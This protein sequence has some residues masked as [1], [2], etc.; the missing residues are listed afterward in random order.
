MAITA[1]SGVRQSPRVAKKLF[2]DNTDIF[3]SNVFYIDLQKSNIRKRLQEKIQKRGGKVD[4]F[5]HKD[6]QYVI[7]DDFVPNNSKQPDNAPNRPGAASTP[8]ALS[9]GQAL[10]QK[11]I[12]NTSSTQTIPEKAKKMGIKVVNLDF[13]QRK[14]K[15]R[16][17]LATTLDY[18]NK[19]PDDTENVITHWNGDPYIKFED[20]QGQYRPFYSSFERFPYIQLESNV[21]YDRP[22]HDAGSHTIH[23]K[24]K[25]CCTPPQIHKLVTK[26]GQKS[27]GLTS[28][29]KSRLAKNGKNEQAGYCE[30]CEITFDNFDKHI[31]SD[32]HRNFAYN[33]T[34]FKGLDAVIAA[35]PS[36]DSFLKSLDTT[37]DFRQHG[38]T[39]P[40]DCG[41]TSSDN[42]NHR[43]RD[44]SHAPHPIVTSPDDDNAN[45][46]KVETSTRTT[47]DK[48]THSLDNNIESITPTDNDI[49]AEIQ[50]T[51]GQVDSEVHPS[52]PNTNVENASHKQTD[53]LDD[54]LHKLA[55]FASKTLEESHDNNDNSSSSIDLFTPSVHWNESDIYDDFSSSD[56]TI[57]SG[58]SPRENNSPTCESGKITLRICNGK[59]YVNIDVEK[60]GCDDHKIGMPP[61]KQAPSID[62]YSSG[63]N[64]LNSS[65]PFSDSATCDSSDASDNSPPWNVDCSNGLK[66][67]FHKTMTTPRQR[68]NN[69][70]PLK[71]SVKQL[72]TCKLTFSASKCNSRKRHLSTSSEDISTDFRNDFSPH[73]RLKS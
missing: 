58:E 57:S 26:N 2:S 13:I 40:T 18:N 55:A 64:S 19:Q 24:P 69:I 3:H 51:D 67:K 52:A 23:L 45:T 6:V 61:V 27:N 15:E 54:E 49:T 47:L 28:V 33:D 9:R 62:G 60:S 8:R 31:V 20:T 25:V 41:D 34:N 14:L 30:M 21:N 29:K 39:E 1:T 48:D 50:D 71:W 12:R 44:A 38:N 46:T 36:L 32:D 63:G 5:L 4:D 37:D 43:G 72:G 65:G 66:M 35:L 7:T 22:K 10:L 11:S 42:N 59:S 68:R 16:G 56:N 73:K 53:E 70:S 17:V